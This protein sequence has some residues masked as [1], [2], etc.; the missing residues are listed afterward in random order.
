MTA[1]QALTFEVKSERPDSEYSGYRGR[2][3]KSIRGKTFIKVYIDDQRRP[4]N[5]GGTVLQDIEW[6]R[7]HTQPTKPADIKRF[8]AD[9]YGLDADAIR[10]RYDRHCGCSMCPCSPGYRVLADNVDAAREAAKLVREVVGDDKFDAWKQSPVDV[11]LAVDV[12]EEAA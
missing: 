10:V 9:R 2:F 12:L 4:M 6:R 11:W 7:N 8:L 1:P 3:L 5:S